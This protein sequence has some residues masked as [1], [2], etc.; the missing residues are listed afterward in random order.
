MILKIQRLAGY[1]LSTVVLLFATQ[2]A[3]LRAQDVTPPSMT[4]SGVDIQPNGSRFDFLFDLNARDD[5]AID[6]IQYRAHVNGN[7]FSPW[8]DYP[9]IPGYPLY[10]SVH[11]NTFSVQVRSVDTSGNLSA[12]VNKDF[13]KPF[14]GSAGVPLIN[15]IQLANPP[16]VFTNGTKLTV[17]MQKFSV[18]KKASRKVFSV[19]KDIDLVY[20]SKA[21][22]SRNA[23]VYETTLV[24]Q[25]SNVVR[26]NNSK[27]NV[28]VL[29]N[30]APGNYNVSYRARLVNGK[31]ILAETTQSPE[32]FV[33]VN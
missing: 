3:L 21:K 11:C 24:N 32:S 18:P 8:Y 31:T 28:L 22:K 13:R 12:T 23:I 5:I 7:P 19:S 15:N 33:V 20:A 2:P 17:I 27:R 9:Y 1:L 6:Y 26:R 29:K 14:K 30:V 25:Q 10:F 4:I 16:A